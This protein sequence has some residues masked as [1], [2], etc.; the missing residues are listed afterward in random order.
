MTDNK[1]YSMTDNA[2]MSDS[3]VIKI[4]DGGEFYLLRRIPNVLRARGYRLYLS[5]KDSYLGKRRLVDLW[6]NGGA[7]VLGHTPPNMLREI[8]NTASRGLYTPYPHFTH[9]RFLKALSKLLPGYNFRVYAA[10]PSVLIKTFP[11]INFWRPFA[12]NLSPFAAEKDT[13]MIVP[14]LP[15]IQTWRN[16]LPIGLCVTAFQDNISKNNDAESQFFKNLTSIIKQLPESDFLPPVLLAA[17]TR[18]INDILASTERVNIN[19]LRIAKIIKNTRW[20]QNGIYLLLKNKVS[21]SEWEV[22]FNQFL[23]EGFLLPPVQ[24][25]PVI[26]PGELSDGEEVKLANILVK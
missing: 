25:H 2:L 9:G 3:A 18:G 10:A 5:D 1:T 17:A 11:H 16:G 24:D 21:D 7:A 26:L 4:P 22:L 15:C 19:Y 8:K 23:D 6:L 14:V 12:D 20:N 13:P